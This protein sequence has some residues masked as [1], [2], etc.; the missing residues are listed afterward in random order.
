MDGPNIRVLIAVLIVGYSISL[1]VLLFE[2]AW[3]RYT[4]YNDLF[5]DYNEN[6]VRKIEWVLNLNG[7][8]K[9]IVIGWKH[10]TGVIGICWRKLKSIVITE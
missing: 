5:G 8:R 4:V 2:I 9:K 1:V 6:L 10:F 7:L 3:H